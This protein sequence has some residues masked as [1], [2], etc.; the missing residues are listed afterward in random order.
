MALQI[1]NNAIPSTFN[2]VC[3]KFPHTTF[4]LDKPQPDLKTLACQW[5]FLHTLYTPKWCMP[6]HNRWFLVSKKRQC[7]SYWP[8]NILHT[9]P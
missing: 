2:L 6:Y 8:N 4:H 7:N 1:G 3:N 9:R 5:R